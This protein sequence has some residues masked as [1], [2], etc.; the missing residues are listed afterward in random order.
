MVS[1]LVVGML[2]GALAARFMMRRAWRRHAFAGRW[3]A[4]PAVVD[5]GRLAAERFARLVAVLE[6]NARQQA[7]FDAALALVQTLHGVPAAEW[8]L[9]GRALAQV[10]SER[11]D[12]G[13]LAGQPAELV[14]ALEHVHNVL[15]PEQRQALAR[16]T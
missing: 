10:A 5:P 6:L 3:H 8:P 12:A 1:P 9:L 13:A 4:R 7:D 15:T 14:D 2:G 16:M 11:F